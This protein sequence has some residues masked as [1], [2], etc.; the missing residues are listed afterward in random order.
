MSCRFVHLPLEISL[1]CDIINRLSSSSAISKTEATAAQGSSFWLCHINILPP[2]LY[3]ASWLPFT[4]FI[5]IFLLYGLCLVQTAQGHNTFSPR[6]IDATLEC[7]LKEAHEAEMMCAVLRPTRLYMPKQ[8]WLT[9]FFWHLP[10]TLSVHSI[11]TT[12]CSPQQS[13]LHSGPPLCLST[14]D[15]SSWLFTEFHL[16]I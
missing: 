7:C 4:A 10:L 3:S 12:E 8:L 2:Q 15:C 14:R 6:C 13:V 16:D 5:M 1:P 9:W 11:S